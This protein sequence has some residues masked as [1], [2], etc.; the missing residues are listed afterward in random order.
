MHHTDIPK[1]WGVATSGK[2]TGELKRRGLMQRGNLQI[3][4]LNGLLLG[5]AKERAVDA[6]CLLGEVPANAARL[7]NPMAAL[8]VL[9]VLTRMLDIKVDLLELEQIAGQAKD[10]LKQMAAEAMGEYI[11]LFT[12]P[13]WEQGQDEEGEE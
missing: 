8:V 9:R 4:G 7:Q 6:M 10:Q 12:E 2:L 5:V 13:I 11:D 1:A 3:A